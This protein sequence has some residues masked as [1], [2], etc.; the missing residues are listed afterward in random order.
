MQLNVKKP[1]TI[2]LRLICGVLKKNII[3]K[4]LENSTYLLFRRPFRFLLIK[5]KLTIATI[6]ILAPIAIVSKSY[7]GVN[8]FHI[9]SVSV[10]LIS[11]VIEK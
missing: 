3:K 11:T 8:H 5:P 4:L 2:K 7:G 6:P 9:L 1:P 10:L